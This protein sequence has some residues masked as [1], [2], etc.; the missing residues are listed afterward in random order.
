MLRFLED[1]RNAQRNDPAARGILEIVLC[2]PGLHA[3]WF[4]RFARALWRLRLPLLPRFVSHI[5]RFLTG[6]EIHPGATLGRRVFI[7]HGDR[8]GRASIGEERGPVGP[9]API[10]R[11]SRH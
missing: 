8:P 3:I 7:D 2:Y 4:H 10:V 1:I 9:L 6:I 11:A 5:A